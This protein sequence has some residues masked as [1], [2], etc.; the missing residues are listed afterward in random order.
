MLPVPREVLGKTGLGE[1]EAGRL[2]AF[3]V[4]NESSGS[5]MWRG[6]GVDTQKD[7]YQGEKTPDGGLFPLIIYILIKIRHVYNPLPLPQSRH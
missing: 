1:K 7:V 3:R 2:L 6:R 4:R 5:H